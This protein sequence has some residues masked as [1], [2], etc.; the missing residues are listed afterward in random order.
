MAQG[1]THRLASVPELPSF[2]RRIA[3]QAGRGLVD[4][5]A[6]TGEYGTALEGWNRVWR[7]R[8]IAKTL[9]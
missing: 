2:S 5:T 4:D 1:P 3:C 6:L 7:N 9:G 8:A